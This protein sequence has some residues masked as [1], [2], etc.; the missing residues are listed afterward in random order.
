VRK[1]LVAVAVV[2]AVLV[3]ADFGLRLLADLLVARE[4]QSALSLSERPSVSLSGFPFIPELIRGNVPS[5]TVYTRGPVTIGELPLREVTLTLRDVSFSPRQLVAGTGTRIH[6]KS[7]EGTAQ[8][9]QGDL[10]AAVRGSIPV[11]VLFRSGKVVVRADQS[12]QELTATP[13][14]SDGRLVLTPARP[15][16]PPVDV[17]LPEIVDGITYESVRIEGAT[18]T[19][20]FTLR[21]GTFGTSGS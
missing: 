17:R 21:K 10:N 16:F 3:A 18:A 9:T 5:V 15:A 13:S 6:A 7:G 2:V 20:S 4:L 19:L 11:R 8:F 12:S 14:I 1:V